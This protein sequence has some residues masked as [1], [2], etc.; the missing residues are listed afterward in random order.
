[1]KQSNLKIY[2]NLKVSGENKL[3]SSYMMLVLLIAIFILISILTIIGLNYIK[4]KSQHKLF[5][6]H[7]RTGM[8]QQNNNCTEVHKKHKTKCENN[9]N[10]KHNT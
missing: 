8:S 10:I 1:M 7:S 5:L 2:L 4:Y 9:T 6:K 3:C